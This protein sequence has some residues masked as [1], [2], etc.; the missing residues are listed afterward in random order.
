MVVH[1]QQQ[2]DTSRILASTLIAHYQA[3]LI[4]TK[5]S[6]LH[7]DRAMLR[8]IEY[9]AESLKVIETGTIRKLWY[10]LLFIFHSNC[11]SILYHFRDKASYWPKI[12]IFHIALHSTPP[13]RGP[14]RSVII[15]LGAESRGLRVHTFCYPTRPVSER[16]LPVPTRT[17][18]SNFLPDSTRPAGLPVTRTRGSIHWNL[19]FA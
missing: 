14:R 17:R 4:I 7:R 16:E 19:Q 6:L 12:A 5:S 1:P 8:V 3:S 11:G 18:T 10:C 9:F 13:V 2:A 15:P